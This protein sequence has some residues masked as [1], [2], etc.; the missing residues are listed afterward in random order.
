MKKLP[1]IILVAMSV[2]IFAAS[3]SLNN[4]ST[5]NPSNG[6]FLVA[7]ISPD[8]PPLTLYSNGAATSIQNLGTGTYTP[9]YQATAG[10]YNFAFYDSA[11]ATSPVLSNTINISTGA[12]YSYFIID[13]FSKVKASFVQ[14]FL[15]SPSPDSVY[16]RF[17]NFSPN[18]GAVSL[19]ESSVFDSSFYSN[20]FFNDQANTTGLAN[21]VRLKTGSLAYYNFQ[22]KQSD[23]T[24]VASKLDTLSA[25]HIYTL[26]AKGNVEGT[27][28][29]AVGIGQILNY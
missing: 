16:I 5:S 2:I 29:Q 14:D 21:F 8:A 11:S 13:S 22:L 7:N 20:R 9:Y 6:G 19:Y 25:G 10:S 12:N 27:G 26:F 24:V 15:P 28:A 18:A 1:L 4:N 17:F 3:C 23:G